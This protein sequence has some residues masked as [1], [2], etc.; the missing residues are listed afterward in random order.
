MEAAVAAAISAGDP[1]RNKRKAPPVDNNPQQSTLSIEPSSKKLKEQE[2]EI[3]KMK[4]QLKRA[5]DKIQ[6]LSRVKEAVNEDSFS[7]KV[8]EGA[9]KKEKAM[10]A[11]VPFEQRYQELVHFQRGHG[12]TR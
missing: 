9:E 7:K 12:H 3:K 1:N 6:K 11:A 2:S 10:A 4:T 8:R 5:K